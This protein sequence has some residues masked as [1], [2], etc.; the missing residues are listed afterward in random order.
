MIRGILL[1]GPFIILST[2]FFGSLNVLVAFFDSVGRAQLWLARMWARS[3]TAVCGI[4]ITTRGLNAIEPDGRYVIASNHTSYID[5]PVILGAIPVQFRFLAKQELFKIP[6][7]GHHLQSAGHVSVPR[8]DPRAAVRTMTQAADNIRNKGISMLVFPEGGRTD[9]G[10]LQP[11]KEGAAYIAIKAGV[12]IVPV[13]LLGARKVLPRRSAL[14]RAG[15]IALRVG[16]PI[17]T[18]GLTLKDREQLTAKVR[19]QI[20]E[21][22]GE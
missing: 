22:L 14:V 16:A 2:I 17:P 20:E 4:R 11:F 7:L 21:M 19:Q 6:L 15:S 13:A 1:N 12:P 8:E 18:T 5:T 9:D 3:I 10:D